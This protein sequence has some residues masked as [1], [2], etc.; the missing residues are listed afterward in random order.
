MLEEVEYLGHEITSQGL[1]PTDE[2]VRAILKAPAPANVSQ[3]KSFLGMLN[4]YGKFLPN[5]STCLTPLYSLLQK[6]AKWTWHQEQ[7]KGFSEG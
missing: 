5:L 6:K 1:Q 3:L 2:K 7:D 4:F